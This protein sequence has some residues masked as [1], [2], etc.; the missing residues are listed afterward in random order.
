MAFTDR[1]LKVPIIIYDIEIKELTGDEQTEESWMKFL[2][3]DLATYRP[4]YSNDAPEVEHVSIMLKCGD[5]AVVLLS[6]TE[7]ENL[8]NLH[9]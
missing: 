8:L 3:L 1:F 2:P 6:I 5:T 7:F 9:D 4:T